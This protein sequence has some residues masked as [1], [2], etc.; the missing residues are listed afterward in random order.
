MLGVAALRESYS[1]NNL[2]LEINSVFERRE[3]R[4]YYIDSLA[5]VQNIKNNYNIFSISPVVSF[6]LL[7]STIVPSAFYK[8]TNY[9]GVGKSYN[10]VGGDVTVRL[11]NML[12]V[13]AGISTFDFFGLKTDVY[14][15]GAR[16]NY[17]NLFTNI[18]LYNKKN[19][20]SAYQLYPNT[21]EPSFSLLETTGSFTGFALNLNYDFWKLRFEEGLN[22]NSYKEDQNT[23]GSEIK[24]H[25]NSG[26]FYKD[27]L[28][29][30]DLDLKTGFVLN[31]Y[32]FESND[33]KSASQLDFTVAGTIRKV[34]IVYFSWENLLN[35]KYFIVPY[36][37]MR[38]RG[39]RFG[40]AWELFN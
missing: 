5:G 10:G 25:I 23:L 21:L 24:M 7:D 32:D 22:Y 8:S 2:H 18:T 33:F 16:I 27:I 35:E 13:Y 37:P 30:Q 34:A 14:Q 3:S 26:I 36:Y 31:Y 19:S 4:Y 12:R 1:R 38:E 11:L 20:A 39:I 9:S 15:I 29:N 28:F 6:Y 40:I 17:E